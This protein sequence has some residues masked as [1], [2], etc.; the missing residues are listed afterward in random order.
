MQFR[1]FALGALI[2][3][4]LPAQDPLHT[5][6]DAFEV[7]FDRAQPV[8]HYTVRATP[9]SDSLGYHVTM[10]VTNAPATLRLAIPV[11]APGAYRLAN[12]HRYI[13]NLTAT[14]ESQSLAVVR[15]IQ[16][17]SSTWRVTTRNGAATIEYDVRYPTAVAAAGLGNYVF[18]RT[19]GALLGGPMT[20]L[21]IVGRTNIPARVTFEL[22]PSWSIAT[23][24][25]PTSSPRTFFAPSYDILIDCPT[26]IGAH[27]HIW[28]FDVDGVPH[29]VAYYTPLAKIPFDSTRFVAAHRRIVTE[30]RDIMGRLPYREYTFIY[31]DG[32]GG[33]LEHL[34]SATMS[35]QRAPLTRDP[36]AHTSLTAHEYFHAWNVKR[37]RPIELGPFR[38]DRPNRTTT[39]WWAEGVTDFFADEI[40]RRTGLRDSIEARNTIAETIE[41]YLANPGHTK[42]SPERASYTS[43]D[44]NTVNRGYSMSYYTTGSL[45]GEMLDLELRNATNGARGMDDVERFLFDHYAGPK[46]YTRDNLR[47]ALERVCGCSFKRF[48]DDYVSGTKPFPLD[49]MLALAG[50]KT[51]VTSVSTDSLGRPLPDLRASITSMNGVGSLGSYAGSPARL[52]LNV[53]NGSF[54][55]AGLV[56]GDFIRTVNGKPIH[57]PDDFKAVLKGTKVGDRLTVEYTRAGAPRRT[58][59]TVLPYRRLH[60]AIVDLPHVTA[61]QG[62]IRHAWLNGPGKR[63]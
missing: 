45:L 10:M 36:H 9:P 17:D 61:R 62:M 21:Y 53:P 47:D 43:W 54:G 15:E 16:R 11:W 31:E 29:R 42:V 38:Y 2:P 18:Y 50:W 55:R 24:L 23:G 13:K 12:F 37:I 28:P 48:F 6:S 59:V 3:F 22:P 34:N 57:T 5:Y 20:Y 40:L 58:I 7:R 19:D 33:G 60:V 26:L 49:A 32:P 14:A 44:P 27:L 46:G 51:L 39:L 1:M 8:V 41:Y 63:D 35:A 25:I 4:A 30:A 52:S 56:D